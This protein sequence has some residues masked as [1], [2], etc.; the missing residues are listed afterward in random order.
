MKEY[1][2]LGV[3]ANPL[4]RQEGGDHYKNYAIQPVDFA[5][6]NGLDLCQA[7]VV[8][9]VCRFRDKGGL[10]DLKKARH[11]IDLLILYEY[12]AEEKE[13]SDGWDGSSHR[14]AEET[15]TPTEPC[16]TRPPYYEVSAARSPEEV[17]INFLSPDR[18]YYRQ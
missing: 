9:Y 1:F 18:G 10:E 14:Q 17:L 6:R 8:K 3:D 11:Y 4:D 2:W 16:C 7:N 12:G 15:G 13:T 5:M